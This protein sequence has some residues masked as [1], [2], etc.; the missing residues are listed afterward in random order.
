MAPDVH[1][2]LLEIVAKHGGHEP[3]AAAEYVQQ[4]QRNR[5]YQRDVY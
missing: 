3:E 1:A 5:R 4:L 2:A